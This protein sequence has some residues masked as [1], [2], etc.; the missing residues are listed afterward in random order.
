MDD[1]EVGEHAIAI[2]GFD[3]ADGSIKF[4]NSWGATWGQNGFGH[5]SKSGAKACL[6]P[7]EIWAVEPV[8]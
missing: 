3:D 8:T 1:R 5:L 6:I 4:A 7:S 2:V